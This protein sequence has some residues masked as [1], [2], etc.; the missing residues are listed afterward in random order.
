MCGR[1]GEEGPGG[2]CA[3]EACALQLKNHSMAPT[4][5]GAFLEVMRQS[6][7]LWMRLL[8]LDLTSKGNCWMV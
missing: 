3:G 4:V 1:V 2:T 7:G 6:E 8:Q 5:L